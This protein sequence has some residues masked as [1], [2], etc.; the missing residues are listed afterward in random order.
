[1]TDNF[2]IIGNLH[3]IRRNIKGEVIEDGVFYICYTDQVLGT[4]IEH[5]IEG[6][7]FWIE[8]EKVKDLAK[9]FK[10]SVEAVIKEI[11]K[12][13]SGKVDFSNQFIYEYLPEVEEY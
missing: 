1:L 4:L 11:Q 3:Q 8:L 7:Y 10:P 5:S 9:L 2:K 13:L 12:R 6:E